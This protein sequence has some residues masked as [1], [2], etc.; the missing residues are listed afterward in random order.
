M[1]DDSPVG[2][3]DLRGRRAVVTG[4]AR[5]IGYAIA[6][7]LARAGARVHALDIDHASMV[8][9][10]EVTDRHEWRGLH[11]IPQQADFGQDPDAATD[12]AEQLL[13]GQDDPV[14]LIVNNVGICTGTGYHDTTPEDFQR[15]YRT[16]VESPWFFT[17][18]LVE[19]LTKSGR[20]GSVVFISSLHQQVPSGRPQYDISKAGVAQGTRS[21]AAQ[22]GTHRIRVNSIS[23]GWI[24]TESDPRRAEA[25]AAKILPLIPLGRPGAADDVAKVALFLLSDQWSG[26]LTGLDIPVDGGLLLRGWT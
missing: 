1:F 12:L 11:C 26:Y 3:S 10:I 24:A 23:P 17:K 16:N 22:L 15:V 7:R 25:K 14:E 8:R 6:L 5:G 13:T 20:S 19:A 9:R 4:A 2:P 18:R 21:L